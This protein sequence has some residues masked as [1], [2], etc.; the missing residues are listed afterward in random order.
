MSQY[1][2]VEGVYV[3]FVTFTVVD[4]LPI[5]VSPEPIQIIVD[6][7]KFCIAQKGLRI[8]S[9][10]IMP[11]HI[12]L[13][14]FDA[15]FDNEHLLQTLINFRKFT[16]HQLAQFADENLPASISGILQDHTGKDRQRQV[17]QTGW[18][19]EGLTSEA[20]LKQKME[21]IHLNPVRKGLVR[22]PEDW[23]CSSA[24]YW[25]CGEEG[26]IPVVEIREEA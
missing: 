1:C 5:F 3:Y 7:L 18:H 2:F 4:W 13:I 9:Y 21:Y 10:V 17:W 26:E 19:A 16:G 12:H 25:L 8:H 24:G 14:V 6:S 22:A 11:N 15:R 23:R 20:F